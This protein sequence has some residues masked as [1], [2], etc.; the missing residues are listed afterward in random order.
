MDSNSNSNSNQF[1]KPSESCFTIYSKS[2]CFN[3]AKVKDFLQENN[4][5]FTIIDC[6]E[7]LLENKAEFLNFIMN[8]TSREW[9]TFPIVFNN[10]QFIGGFIDIKLYLDKTTFDFEEDF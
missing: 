1:T 10:S 5:P 3:C 2:G 9:R 4:I 7:Y 6:D 8:L